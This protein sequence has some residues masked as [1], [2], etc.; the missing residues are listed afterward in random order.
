MA[1]QNVGTP[2]FYIDYLS[3]WKSLGLIE[4][5]RGYQFGGTTIDKGDPV[6]LD[7]VLPCEISL[8]THIPSGSE[9]LT[10]L[11]WGTTLDIKTLESINYVGLLGHNINQTF[12]DSEPGG[13]KI[14]FN[15]MRQEGA[16]IGSHDW[17][18]QLGNVTSLVNAERSEGDGEANNLA[19]LPN[20][21][22]SI[23][24]VEF[25]SSG[26]LGH[27]ID[28]EGNTIDLPLES[29]RIT[30]AMRWLKD[31]S[32]LTVEGDLFVNSFCLG[33][34]YDMPVSPDLSLSM[35]IQFDGYDSIKTLGGSTLNRT[36]YKGSPK[37][38]ELNP[39]EIGESNGIMNRNGRRV[40]SLKF[41]YFA[42]EDLFASNYMSNT[43]L[44]YNSTNTDYDTNSDLNSDNTEFEYTLDNDSSFIAK[45]LNF[46]GN[47]ERFI[48][49]ANKD[50]SNPSDFAICILDQK[51]FKI[52]Q[53]AYKVYNI[54]MKIMEVW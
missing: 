26:F 28:D 34:Y 32:A 38:G 18:G 24:G 14:A 35:E 50:S 45:V 39:W 29:D 52:S 5:T 43:H 46:V 44:N 49:Q 51:S 33:H 16:G 53:K 9:I 22:F 31:G 2:R 3:Y 8:D 6:G 41:S 25:D 21:G 23:W 48:F 19:I 47:G 37:W 10:D 40:W 54:S 13:A 15:K 17:I 27:T 30:L 36:R 20:S 12:D 7:P 1:Y 42:D 11:K 4:T